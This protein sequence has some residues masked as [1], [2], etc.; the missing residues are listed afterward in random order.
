MM[1]LNFYRKVS[2]NACD[3]PVTPFCCFSDIVPSPLCPHC[4]AKT[5]NKFCFPNLFAGRFT[6]YGIFK[7]WIISYQLI[8]KPLLNVL[9]SLGMV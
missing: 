6:L 8:Q 7:V 1:L 2:K 3:D 5:L 9:A 4:M